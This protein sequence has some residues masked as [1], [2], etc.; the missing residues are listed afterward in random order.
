MFYVNST[1]KDQNLYF[2]KFLSEGFGVRSRKRATCPAS[3]S[4]AG[5]SQRSGKRK[6]W[7]SGKANSGANRSDASGGDDSTS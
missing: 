6:A 2:K 5:F 1:K 3:A 7:C 4:A